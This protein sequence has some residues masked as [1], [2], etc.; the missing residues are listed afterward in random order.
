MSGSFGFASVSVHGLRFTVYAPSNCHT[1]WGPPPRESLK[2]IVI[3]PCG[4]FVFGKDIF[5]DPPKIPSFKTSIKWTFIGQFLP[6]ARFFLPSKVKGKK[7]TR[8]DAQGRAAAFSSF[9]NLRGI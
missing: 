6:N 4:L 8:D 5:R 2:V 9:E 3:L 7:V 1:F